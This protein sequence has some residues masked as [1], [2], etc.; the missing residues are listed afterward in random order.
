MICLWLLFTFVLFVAEP[1]IVARHFHKWATAAPRD[2]FKW[3]HPGT[4]F[5]S[6]SA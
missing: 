5:C 4:W 1:F 6:R 2:A 3:L